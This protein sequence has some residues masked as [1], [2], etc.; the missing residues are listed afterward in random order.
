ME[1]KLN[2][3]QLQML[4]R[5]CADHSHAE[6]PGWAIDSVTLAIGDE[7]W[8]SGPGLYVIDDNIRGDGSM[9]LALDEQDEARAIAVFDGKVAAGELSVSLEAYEKAYEANDRKTWRMQDN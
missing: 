1:I 9:F 3:Y 4:I 7:S 2:N 6:A 5:N 8:H